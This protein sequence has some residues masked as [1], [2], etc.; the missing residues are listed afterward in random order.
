[1]IRLTTLLGIAA[2]AVAFSS[3][4][5]MTMPWQQDTLPPVELLEDE[6]SAA[7]TVTPSPTQQTGLVMA[8]NQRF[9]DIPL[10]MKAKEDLDRSYVYE[11][12]SLQVGRMVYTIRADVNDIAQFYIDHCPA[13]DWKLVDTK[14]ADG[15]HEILF[16]K[17]GKKLEVSIIPLSLMQGKRLVLHLVPDQAAESVH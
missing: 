13:A 6:E 5:S 9:K 1:M 12:P 10:P 7:G 16:R 3:C 17:S 15:G 8:P 2:C 14:Q 11:S 4:Q